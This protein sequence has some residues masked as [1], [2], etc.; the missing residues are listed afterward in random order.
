LDLEPRPL[1]R[2]SPPVNGA[3]AISGSSYFTQF[4]SPGDNFAAYDYQLSF[5]LMSTQFVTWK[6]EFTRRGSNVPYFTG[7]GGCGN[8]MSE[9]RRAGSSSL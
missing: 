1:S 2:A 9:N 7:P 8:R 6:A 4:G 5:D 3:T